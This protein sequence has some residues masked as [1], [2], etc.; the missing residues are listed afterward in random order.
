MGSFTLRV[1]YRLSLFKSSLLYS[2]LI[3]ENP[4]PP[5]CLAGLPPSERLPAICRAGLYPSSEQHV[6]TPC[7]SERPD[8]VKNLLLR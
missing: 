4:C 1:G 2:V 5:S 7:H 3:C 6:E 8:E